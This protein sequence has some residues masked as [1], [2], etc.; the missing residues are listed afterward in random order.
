MSPH[1]HFGLFGGTVSILLSITPAASAKANQAHPSNK[2]FHPQDRFALSACISDASAAQNYGSP[3]SP[4]F[5]PEEVRTKSLALYPSGDYTHLLLFQSRIF[6][7]LCLGNFFFPPWECSDCPWKYCGLLKIGL[8]LNAAWP[9]TWPSWLTYDDCRDP[10][11][12]RSTLLSPSE[13]TKRICNLPPF[14]SRTEL[15]ARTSSNLN[16][17]IKWN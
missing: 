6:H 12:Q 16:F 14:W 9:E 11:S 5:V 3:F 15:R 10:L 2:K 7:P 1:P 8:T 13:F 4:S 17:V